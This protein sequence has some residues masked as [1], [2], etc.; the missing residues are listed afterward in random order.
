MPDLLLSNGSHVSS[1]KEKAV[2]PRQLVFS[3]Y[4]RLSKYPKN[5]A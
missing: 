2:E 3:L 4:F 5:G 1:V